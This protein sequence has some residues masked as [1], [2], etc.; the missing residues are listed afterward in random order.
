MCV[1]AEELSRSWEFKE[2]IDVSQEMN[3]VALDVVVKSLLGFE[4][5]HQEKDI[6]DAIETIKNLTDQKKSAFV[7]ALL[8]QLPLPR[9]VAYQKAYACLN[10]TI[11]EIIRQ[12]RSQPEGGRDL[13]ATLLAAKGS[14]GCPFLSDELV[15]DEVM[16]M[17]MAGHE[18]IAS[19]MTWT[20]YLLS[21]NPD[22][23]EKFHAELDSVLGGRPMRPEDVVSLSYTRKILLESMRIYPPVWLM[24][25]HPLVETELGGYKI[26]PDSYIH[27]CQY[28]MHRDS[29]YYPDPE[30]FDPER[31]TP[32]EI[33]KRPKYSYFPFGGGKRRCIGEE[34]AMTEGIIV[35]ATIARQWQLRRDNTE[36]IEL[37][38]LITL[39]P[40]NGMKMTLKKR[41]SKVDHEYTVTLR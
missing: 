32:E 26:P 14:Q 17:F 16:T 10:Q 21:C 4:M 23:E 33:N 5:I 37:E 25:R 34:F 1:L 3:R 6:V 29:R 35:L 36:T 13:V 30:K 11:Y 20:W 24:V 27:L 38:P 15:R 31:W 18:T 7:D 39:R 9:R 22:V 19:A 28:T 2:T 12:K 8:S 40:K 41:Y